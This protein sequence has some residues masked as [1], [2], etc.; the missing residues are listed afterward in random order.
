MSYLQRRPGFTLIELLVVIAIIAILVAL[1]IPAVQRVREASSRSACQNNLKQ[2][3]LAAHAYESVNKRLPPGYN[4]VDTEANGLLEANYPDYCSSPSLG[5]LAYLLPYVEQETVFREFAL[6]GGLVPSDLFSISTT[7]TRRWYD[8]PPVVQAA[9]TRIPIFRCPLDD[10]EASPTL[11]VTV[12]FHTMID[13]HTGSAGITRVY[14]ERNQPIDGSHT[15]GDLG[16]TNYVGV[17]GYAGRASKYIGDTNYEGLMCNRS[18]IS[19]AMLPA[20]DGT[21]N[22]MMF[23]E[24]LGGPTIGPLV[25]ANTW[26]GAGALLT[27]YG[28]PENEVVQS[29]GTIAP[30]SDW[31]NFAS[32]HLAIVNFCFADG[33]VRPIRRTGDFSTYIY[34]SG[35]NDGRTPD[36]SLVE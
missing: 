23:G 6:G 27:G 30:G 33:S 10:P 21:S 2:I 28:L 31:Y 14:V 17:S 34:L 18:N 3:G 7:E 5:V 36:F 24:T 15:M 29:D 16:Q 13:F 1:L 11:G 20:A 19:L 9:L 25:I 26:M 12:I 32:R 35:W 22:T 8:F 4:G